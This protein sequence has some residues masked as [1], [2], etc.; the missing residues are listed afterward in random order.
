LTIPRGVCPDSFIDVVN[1][2]DNNRQL[3]IRLKV[4]PHPVFDVSARDKYNLIVYHALTLKELENKSW[5]LHVRT[6]DGD[7]ELKFDNVSHSFANNHLLLDTPHSVG[8]YGLYHRNQLS[9][10]ALFIH[11]YL[12]NGDGGLEA[13]M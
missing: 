9:R 8:S 10:G 11:L 13:S 1:E 12:V 6:I 7:R 3:R 4:Q 5:T 2:K